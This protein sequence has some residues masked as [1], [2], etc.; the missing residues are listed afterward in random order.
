MAV[1]ALEGAETPV[2]GA[3]GGS[4]EGSINELVTVRESVHL[5]PF[6]TEIIEGQVKPSSDVLLT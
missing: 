6:Q 4:P 2:E 3:S 5:R 1:L